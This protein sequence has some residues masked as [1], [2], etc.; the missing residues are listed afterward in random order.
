MQLKVMKTDGSSEEYLHTKVMGTFNNA[1]GLID[2][3]NVFAAE[4]FAEA[5]TFYLYEKDR[6]RAITS[7]EIHL[8]VQAILAATGYSNAAEA[9]NDYQLNRKLSRRRIEVF[10]DSIPPDCRR[11][12]MPWDKSMIVNDL[13]NQQDLDYHIARAIASQVEQKVLKLGITRIRR[14]LVGLLVVD[15]TEAMLDAQDQLHTVQS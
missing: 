10:D 2:Q 14:S 9:I 1:L 15:D 5:I 4:Q 6:K 8:M 7:D 12:T 13:I 3:S 11:P